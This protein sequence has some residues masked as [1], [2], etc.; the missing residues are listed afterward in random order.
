MSW[1]SRIANVFRPSDLD[2]DFDDEVDFHIDSRIAD[3]VAAGTTRDKAEY[4]GRWRS[5]S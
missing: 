2:R 3:L 4:Y 1:L 5:R